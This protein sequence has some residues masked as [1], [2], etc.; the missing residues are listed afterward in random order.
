M[1]ATT[2]LATLVA[3][4]TISAAVCADPAE[5]WEKNCTKC[6]GADGAGKTKMGEKIGVK[7]FTDAKYQATFTDEQAIKAIKEG[8]KDGEKVRMK[9]LEG[10]TDDDAKALVAKVRGFKK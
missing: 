5:I 3:F 10:A 8:V 6:H 1:K 4:G 2:L 9:P 7:D